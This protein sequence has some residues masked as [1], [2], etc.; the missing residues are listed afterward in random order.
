MSRKWAIALIALAQQNTSRAAAHTAISWEAATASSKMDYSYDILISSLHRLQVRPISQQTRCRCRVSLDSAWQ[1]PALHPSQPVAAPTDIKR[2]PKHHSAVQQA[3]IG[4]RVR[5]TI[6]T[7]SRVV[8]WPSRQ[9]PRATW[10]EDASHRH[11]KGFHRSG[12]TGIRPTIEALTSRQAIAHV[13]IWTIQES[14]LPD[15]L[16]EAVYLVFKHIYILLLNFSR[17]SYTSDFQTSEH[18]S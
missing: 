6:V 15:T 18:F 1:I 17:L 4:F 5:T 9:L 11:R 10:E 12:T 14:A 3:C 2:S 8:L 13:K 16:Y 7:K